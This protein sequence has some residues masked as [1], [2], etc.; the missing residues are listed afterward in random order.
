MGML[1]ALF[2]GVIRG[3]LKHPQL[4]RWRL[5]SIKAARVQIDHIS[6]VMQE[7]LTA[8]TDERSSTFE[9]IKKRLD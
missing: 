3:A 4:N 7:I 2:P 6:V 1:L 8:A 5:T 9:R